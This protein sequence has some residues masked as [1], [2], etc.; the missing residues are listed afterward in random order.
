MSHQKVTFNSLP[1]CVLTI[2]FAPR[3]IIKTVFV[4]FLLFKSPLKI[5]H[6]Y[7]VIKYTTVKLKHL[8]KRFSLQNIFKL[9][10]AS[11]INTYIVCF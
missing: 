1:L 5:L 7:T 11:D 9:K 4:I 2:V 10:V 3:E 6:T 8:L